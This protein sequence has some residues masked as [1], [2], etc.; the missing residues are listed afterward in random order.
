MIILYFCQDL[1]NGPTPNL[2]TPVEMMEDCIIYG[3]QPQLF[4]YAISIRNVNQQVSEVFEVPLELK[5]N[6]KTYGCVMHF[7]TFFFSGN[8]FLSIE[9]KWIF[10]SRFHLIFVCVAH[11][12][13]TCSNVHPIT[14]HAS[15]KVKMRCVPYFFMGDFVEYLILCDL[16]CEMV[17]IVCKRFGTS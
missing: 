11:I 14:I 15:G 4:K 13:E 8:S 10:K 6:K 5:S 16:E 1:M 12:V 17:H 2:C 9:F 3:L 7:S